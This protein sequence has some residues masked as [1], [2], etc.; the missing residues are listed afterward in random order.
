MLLCVLA[1]LY[2]LLMHDTK[3][4]E[5]AEEA[6]IADEML[7]S[8]RSSMHVIRLALFVK[9]KRAMDST[10]T[11]IELPSS[12]NVSLGRFGQVIE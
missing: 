2:Y 12:A 3:E 5:D 9:N 6:I 11:D 7:I 8:F 1:T 4:R 10:H